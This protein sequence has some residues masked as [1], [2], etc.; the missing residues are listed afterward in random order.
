MMEW[1]GRCSECN[2]TI[3]DWADA[4]LFRGRWIHKS[5]FSDH[6]AAAAE[7]L[8]SPTERSA[9]LELPMLIFVLMFHFGLGAAVA[10]WVMLTQL[11]EKI[12]GGVIVLAIGVVVPLIGAAGVALNVVGRRRIELIRQE[13]E[14]QGGWKSGH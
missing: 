10:G 4:G 13:L 8:R 9:Q 14:S 3:D 2:R 5:C 11:S 6:H 12:D 1:P 7:A